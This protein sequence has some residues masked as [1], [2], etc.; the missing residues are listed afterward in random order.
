MEKQKFEIFH[1]KMYKYELEDLIYI[2]E[3]VNNENI[4]QQDWFKKKIEEWIDNLK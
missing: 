3:Q 4:S 1:L 2:L